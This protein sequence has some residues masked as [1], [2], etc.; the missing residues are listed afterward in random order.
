MCY[1]FIYLLADLYVY[2][3]IIGSP[4]M[5]TNSFM[6]MFNYLSITILRYIVAHHSV[7]LYII[8]L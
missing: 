4:P 7:T 6:C 2:L 8:G 1:L 5:F 3:V